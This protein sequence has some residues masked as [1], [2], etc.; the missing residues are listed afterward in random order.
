M[1]VKTSFTIAKGTLAALDRLVGRNG[2]RS[3]FVET[4]LDA[5][6]RQREREERDA[7]DLELYRGHAAAINREV[8]DSMKLLAELT[9]TDRRRGRRTRR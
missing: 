8:A 5:A 6:I 7:R 9:P 3:A 4:A 2:N 1:K